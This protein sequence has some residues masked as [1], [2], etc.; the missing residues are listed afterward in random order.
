MD[1]DDY[2]ESYS[3]CKILTLRHNPR[4]KIG[5]R[6]TFNQDKDQ[7]IVKSERLEKFLVSYWVKGWNIIVATKTRILIV[8]E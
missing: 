8:D 4:E 2:E 6:W 1:S 3:C 7:Y 5:Q